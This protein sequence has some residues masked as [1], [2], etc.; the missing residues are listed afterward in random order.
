MFCDCITVYFFVRELKESSYLQC[1]HCHSHR[2]PPGPASWRFILG[3]SQR[4]CWDPNQLT[5]RQT[6]RS[7][8]ANTAIFAEKERT[9]I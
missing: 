6:A 7:R 4:F 3:P 2:W 5:T 9:K 1:C 8:K